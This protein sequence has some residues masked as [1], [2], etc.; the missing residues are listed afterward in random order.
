[1]S[2]KR[3][4]MF[5]NGILLWIRMIDRTGKPWLRIL[6]LLLVVPMICSGCKRNAT[7][8]PE[9]AEEDTEYG[10]FTFD[11]RTIEAARL[12]LIHIM[13][14]YQDIYMGADKGESANVVLEDKVIQD[15]QEKL[16]E[17]GLPVYTSVPYQ[18]MLGGD[19]M[20]QFLDQCKKKIP[21]SQTI[22]KVHYDGGLS[23]EEYRF[24]GKEMQLFSIISSWDAAPAPGISLASPAS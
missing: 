2:W 7:G 20:D 14:T 9:I 24:D 19:K 18:N 13:E 5:W 21:G 17:S 8:R 12:D 15:I 1:M 10:D 22:Y 23:R 16:A 6:S 4:G 11:N 3:A